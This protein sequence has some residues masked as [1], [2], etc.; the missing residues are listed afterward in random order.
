MN[1]LISD[2]RGSFSHRA[3]WAYAVWLDVVTKYRRTRLGILWLVLPPVAYI[4]GLGNLYAVI[5]GRDPWYFV[6]HLGVGYVL[7]RF[8]IQSVTESADVFTVHQAFIMDGR[9]RF[10]DYVLRVFARSSLYM[11]VGFLVLLVVFLVDPLVELKAIPL[12]LITV[13]IYVLNV[14]WMAMLVALVGARYRDTRELISTGLIF[15]FLLTPIIWDAS[16]VPPD[17][18]RG[19][20]VRFN[21]FFHLIEFVRAPI[22]GHFPEVHSLVAVAALTLFGWGAAAVVYS[23]YSRFIPLWL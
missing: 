23:R 17:S 6:P 3:F 12:L 15:G 7:W 4:L 19:M 21:P 9:V 1:R 16:L 5:V 2:F 20:V 14:L 18:I 13:P 11:A 8:A 22:L 10:T